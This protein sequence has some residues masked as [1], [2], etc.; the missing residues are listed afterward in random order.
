MTKKEK[1]T[2]GI[3]CAIDEVNQQ[4]RLYYH[5]R[6][7]DGRQVTRVAISD[8]GLSFTAQPEVLGLPYFRLFRQEKYY[9]A[10]GMPGVLYRSHDGLTNFE[11][12]PT[13]TN[14]P[15]RHIAI[16]KH[17]EDRYVY[18]LTTLYISRAG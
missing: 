11:C 5:G 12:G 17:N 2:E 6:L 14:Q 10:V 1:V 4:I 15:I 18:G 8:D 9:Y 13:I 16:Y 3:F 7:S